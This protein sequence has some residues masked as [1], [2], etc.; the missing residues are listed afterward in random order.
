V[1]R[2]RRINRRILFD[3]RNR[4]EN[5]WF[6]FSVY[7]GFKFFASGAFGNLVGFDFNLD[8]R[9]KCTDMLTKGKKREMQS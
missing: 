3:Y 9:A 4:N 8:A 6:S 5:R 7:F 1:K 2:N